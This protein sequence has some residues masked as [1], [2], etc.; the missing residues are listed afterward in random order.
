LKRAVQLI[1]GVLVATGASIVTGACGDA[2]PVTPTDAGADGLTLTG[3]GAIIGPDGEIIDLND[4]AGTDGG[5]T[6]PDGAPVGEGGVTGSSCAGVAATCGGNKDCCASNEVVG[7][8]FNRS[9]ESSFPATISTFKLDVYE[10]TVGRFRTFVNAG[11]G[12]QANPPAVGDGA[13]PKIAG[14]GWVS[15][16]DTELAADTA[17]LKAALKCDAAYPAWTD[18]PGANE[19]KPINCVTWFDALAFCAWDG[20]RLPTEAEWNYA[21]AGGS[22]QREYPWG[23]TID[24]TKAS[25]NCQG[26]GEGKANCVFSDMLPVGSKSPAGDGKYGQTDLAGNVWEWTL[27]WARNPYRLAACSDCADLQI[28]PNKT[29]RGGGFPNES[30]YQTTATRVDDVPQDRDY[31]VGF[32]C[33]R[34]AQ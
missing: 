16:F 13:N 21:A 24:A 9:N 15:A 23:A 1:V 5:G 26:K 19:T 17:A 29:F 25:Y 22:E 18:A 27:D 4:A 20:G 28:A 32:R 8:T 2:D 12:T 7:G 30:F 31:D 6:L 10:V 11:R 14:S 34:S 33:A 3:D